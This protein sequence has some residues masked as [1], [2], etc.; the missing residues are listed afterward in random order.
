MSTILNLRSKSILVFYIYLHVLFSGQEHL[1]CYRL[2]DLLPQV[3][4]MVLYDGLDAR[5]VVHVL[6]EL[7]T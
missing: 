2:F 3:L 6:H 5:L 7:A 1:F 4:G